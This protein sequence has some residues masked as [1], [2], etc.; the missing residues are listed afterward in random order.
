MELLTLSPL[1]DATCRCCAPRCAVAVSAH[2]G[3]LAP[4]QKQGVFAFIASQIRIEFRAIFYR[5]N[6]V[7]YNRTHLKDLRRRCRSGA[8]RAHQ[9]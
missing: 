5:G 3:I 9:K 1:I 2:L 4:S 7:H 8:M 6:R